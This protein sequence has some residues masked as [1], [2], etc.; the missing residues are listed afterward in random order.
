MTADLLRFLVHARDF[1]TRA[2]LA[3]LVSIG[4]FL[5]GQHG[6]LSRYFFRTA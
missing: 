1:E 5:C 2:A 6:F 3:D 4:Y